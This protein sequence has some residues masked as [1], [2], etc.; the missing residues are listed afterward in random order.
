MLE[1]IIE[2]IS[3]N[4]TPICTLFATIVGGLIS[5]IS[6][7][8]A[9]NR[10][11]KY[12]IRREKLTEI[13]VP[14]C[15]TIENTIEI[16]KSIYY[17]DFDMSINSFKEE[18]EKPIVYLKAE[19]RVYL[20]NKQI[21]LLEQYQKILDDFFQMWED[22][23]KYIS[24]EYVQ[25]IKPTLLE[26]PYAPLN[27]YSVE[28]S[29]NNQGERLLYLSLIRQIECIL[30]DKIRGVDYILNADFD[31]PVVVG[32]DIRDKDIEEYMLSQF[33]KVIYNTEGYSG[34]HP[35]DFLKYISNITDKGIIIKYIEQTESAEMFLEVIN[36]LKEVNKNVIKEIDRITK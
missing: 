18:L 3:N 14:Y 26:F 12:S 7:S 9:E 1:K 5:Y 31:N 23:Y 4:F 19:K 13:L 10:K 27:P 36:K 30:I 28:V 34:I 11:N 22:D 24:D 33:N 32:V 8:V 2:F 17:D 21:C 6:T 35:I 16:S 29:F 15:T 20:S 25:C